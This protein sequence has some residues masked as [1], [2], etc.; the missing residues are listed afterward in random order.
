MTLKAPL[1]FLLALGSGVS[2]AAPD[3]AADPLLSPEIVFCLRPLRAAPQPAVND[4]VES[5]K[6]LKLF[7]EKQQ[8]MAKRAVDALVFIFSDLFQKELEFTTAETALAKAERQAQAKEKLAVREETVGSGLS[9]PNPQLAGM[10]RKEVAA[11][12]GQAT[13]QRDAALEKLKEKVNAYNLSVGYFQSQGN[14]EVVL[15]LAS[16][17]FAII[18]RRLPGFEFKPTVSREWVAEQRQT[19]G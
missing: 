2:Y 3:Q 18:D 8:G 15:A 5:V 7:A 6:R 11:I 14:T 10:Y 13:R 4:A 17:L 19:G 9:G 1:L 12:R 16:S